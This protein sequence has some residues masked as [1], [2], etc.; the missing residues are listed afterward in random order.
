[1]AAGIKVVVLL[2]ETW[3]AS[4]GGLSQGLSTPD[5]APSCSVMWA[6]L[7]RSHWEKNSC[8]PL[9]RGSLPGMCNA[10]IPPDT[11]CAHPQSQGPIT[12]QSSPKKQN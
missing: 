11:R 9:P 1:M 4:V 5:P 8:E 6:G 7:E 12:S 3:A 10:V 2:H